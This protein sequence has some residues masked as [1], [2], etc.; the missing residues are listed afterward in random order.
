MIDVSH[1]KATLGMLATDFVFQMTTMTPELA[2]HCPNFP[3]VGTLSA[4]LAAAPFRKRPDVMRS[5]KSG[6]LTMSAE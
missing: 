6:V 1:C 5:N 4:V 2:P 3:N